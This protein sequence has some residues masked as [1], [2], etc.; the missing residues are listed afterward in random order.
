MAIGLRDI[1]EKLKE[2]VTITDKVRENTDRIVK[3]DEE[4][5][6][7]REEFRLSD[8]ELKGDIREIL[9]RLD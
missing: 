2:L 8:A 9:T 3:L 6:A 5:R 1:Y 7:Y 4:F